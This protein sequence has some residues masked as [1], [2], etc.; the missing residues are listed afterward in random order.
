MLFPVITTN[1]LVAQRPCQVIGLYKVASRECFDTS[2]FALVV[3][4]HVTL[5][6]MPVPAL[7]L[8]RRLR[9]RLA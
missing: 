2:E 1:S 7:L 5:V 3:A 8:G 6:T 9:A 4:T